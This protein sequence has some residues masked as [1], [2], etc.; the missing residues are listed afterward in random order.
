MALDTSFP[1]L[2]NDQIA[3]EQRFNCVV[4]LC[5]RL[6][7]VYGICQHRVCV[8]CLYGENGAIRLSMLK[9]P[10]CQNSNVFPPWKPDILEDTVELQKCLGI[11]QCGNC[12]MEL[13]SWELENHESGCLKKKSL[14]KTPT[15]NRKMR[16]L[17]KSVSKRRSSDDATSSSRQLRNRAGTSMLSRLRSFRK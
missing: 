3:M 17:S 1:C 2:T 12:G 11:Q 16:F 5:P 7:M 13:W 8:E 6:K 10:I 14:P 4:C 15:T 9:C